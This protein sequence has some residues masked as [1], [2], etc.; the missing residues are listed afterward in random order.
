MSL[1]RVQTR[2]S[3]KRSACSDCSNITSAPLL[4]PPLSTITSPTVMACTAP[5]TPLTTTISFSR[6]PSTL[7]PIPSTL[8]AT[9]SRP[10]PPPAPAFTPEQFAQ[11]LTTLSSNLNANQ[12]ATVS[13]L[14]ALTQSLQQGQSQSSSGYSAKP[15]TFH[16][17]G[18]ESVDQF[19]SSFERHADFFGW[20]P[21][22]R[23][24][25]LPLSLV[26]HANIWFTSLDSDSYRTYDELTGLL[27]EQFN[28]PASQWLARQQ[29][30]Q[31]KMAPSESVA[32]YSADIRR[33]CQLLRIPKAEWLHVFISGLRSD[34]KQH[35]VLQQPQTFEQAE[36][37]AKL[38]EAVSTADPVAMQTQ[39]FAQALLAQLQKA[40]P[41]PSQ[42]QQVAAFSTAPHLADHAGAEEPMTLSSIRAI[43]Q[44]EIRQALGTL[45]KDLA[46]NSLT[47]IPAGIINSVIAVRLKDIQFAILVTAQDTSAITAL[48]S[49]IHNEILASLKQIGIFLIGVLNLHHTTRE[50]CSGFYSSGRCRNRGI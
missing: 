24:R 20:T 16:G 38:K 28:S 18:I 32:D 48:L 2:A 4:L 40:S 3:A 30:N 13:Q 22:K 34:I 35:L 44:K 27:R 26:G 14:T 41:T 42:P 37:Q 21:V 45:R 36:Q 47:I 15:P 10:S 8:P 49:R 23:L 7:R 39:Q 17:D 25:A 11:V 50:T 33:R 1:N 12:Q 46:S 9:S 43:I 31:R 29:L 6:D 5:A 19:L